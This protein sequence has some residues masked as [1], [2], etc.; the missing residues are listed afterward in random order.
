MLEQF[1]LLK[2][3][4]SS[5]GPQQQSGITLAEESIK[6]AIAALSSIGY[7]DHAQLLNLIN[8]IAVE[9]LQEQRVLLSDTA[10]LHHKKSKRE[11]AIE[12]AA[13]EEYSKFELKLKK[14]RSKWESIAKKGEYEET[15]IISPL[16][17]KITPIGA[18]IINDNLEFFKKVHEKECEDKTMLLPLQQAC[19]CGS[20]RIASFILE[21]LKRNYTSDGYLFVFGYATASDNV[22]WVERMASELVSNGET[23]PAYVHAICT[24]E[25]ILQKIVDKFKANRSTKVEKPDFF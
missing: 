5:V 15:R 25:V 24:N 9:Q 11:L 1:E 6:K 4:K 22:E 21:E 2:K 12:E 23:L 10:M 19:L 20:E 7:D 8:S 18:A 16:L 17:Q 3:M 13:G 14:L